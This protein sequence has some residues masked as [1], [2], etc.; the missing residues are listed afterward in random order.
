MIKKTIPC[1]ILSTPPPCPQNAEPFRRAEGWLCS[2]WWKKPY[3]SFCSTVFYLEENRQRN[4]MTEIQ[5]FVVVLLFTEACM[6][7]FY[8]LCLKNS[9]LE[10]YIPP[11]FIEVAFTYIYHY[12]CLF[13]FSFR[14][15]ARNDDPWQ[16]LMTLPFG[17]FVLKFA[18]DYFLVQTFCLVVPWISCMGY[19]F[20]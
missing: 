9:F 12:I 20:N 6:S 16:I 13:P 11:C 8:D 3:F 14:R 17:L 15:S 2:V 1:S 5:R 4:N 19:R 18:S 7:V 10:L